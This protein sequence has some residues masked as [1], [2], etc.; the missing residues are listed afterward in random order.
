MSNA[1]PSRSSSSSVDLE[2]VRDTLSYIA[3]DLERG[4]QYAQLR[5]IVGLALAEI[6]RIESAD[7]K[8]KKQMLRGAHFIPAR[9]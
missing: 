6:G 5:C 2:A 9:P 1:G 7:G 4:Q 3:S 8:T